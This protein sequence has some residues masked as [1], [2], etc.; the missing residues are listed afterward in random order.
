MLHK[1]SYLI[2]FMRCKEDYLAGNEAQDEYKLFFQTHIFSFQ[3][4]LM[5]A[6]TFAYSLSKSKSLLRL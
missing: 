4:L 3:A 2:W 6:V 5:D 1:K